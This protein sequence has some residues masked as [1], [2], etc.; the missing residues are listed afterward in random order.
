M[1]V[2]RPADGAETLIAWKMALDNHFT[3]TGLI[4]SRQN[5]KDLP[6]GSI[7]ER[8]QMAKNSDKGAYVVKNTIEKPDVILVA[9]GSEVSTL[10]D[11]ANLLKERD[12]INAR[13]VSAISEGVFLKQEDSYRKEIIPADIPVLGLTAGLPVTMEGLV[14]C[15]GKVLGVD[16]FGYSAPYQVLDEEFGFSGEQVRIKILQFLGKHD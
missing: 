7:D 15:N 6:A 5:I 9:S 12:K 14:G 10:I 4:L 13:V 11:A 1:L 16:H 8:L 2:L 3:P